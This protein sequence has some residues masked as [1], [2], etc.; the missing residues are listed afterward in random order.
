MTTE[1]RGIQAIPHARLKIIPPK[2]AFGI[3][4]V[5]F[6]SVF[7]PHIVLILVF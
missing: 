6:L 7:S 3:L 5:L 2:G 1:E 4:E